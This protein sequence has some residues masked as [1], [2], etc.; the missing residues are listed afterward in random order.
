MGNAMPTNPIYFDKPFSSLMLN[1]ETFKIP[2]NSHIN[3]EVE[4]CVIIGMEGKNIPKSDWKKHLLGY[5]VGIDYTDR[6]LNLE[7]KKNNAPW[8]FSKG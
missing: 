6:A 1:D 7:L 3:F 2:Q 4:L 8:C 5:C